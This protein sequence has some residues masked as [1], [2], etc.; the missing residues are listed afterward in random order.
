MNITP[1]ISDALDAIRGE[2]LGEDA[3]LEALYNASESVGGY[4][5]AGVITSGW[6]L[7]EAPRESESPI[8]LKVCERA[9]FGITEMRAV[10]AFALYA[11]YLNLPTGKAAI[12]KI[13]SPR[14]EPV[15]GLN[16]TWTF[17][18]TFTGEL[19]P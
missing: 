5:S 18:V 13:G 3:T 8:V 7:N 9:G 17:P 11:S 2:I 1:D 10:S 19:W 6:F 15:H 16:R 12:V 14:T 4:A